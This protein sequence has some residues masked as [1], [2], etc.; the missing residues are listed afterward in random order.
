MPPGSLSGVTRF[1]KNPNP[2]P[3]EDYEW[4]C[5]MNWH[6]ND[7]EKDVWI[8]GLK[9]EA[10]RSSLRQLLLKVHTMGFHRIRALRKEGHMLPRATELP[11]G[12]LV[13]HV[14]SLMREHPPTGFAPLL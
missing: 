11:D 10:S 3:F 13:M 1:Y 9:G 4:V 6:P 12:S 8:H 7:P 14:S 5:M 2:Q